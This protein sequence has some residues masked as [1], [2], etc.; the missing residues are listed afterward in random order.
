MLRLHLLL[1]AASA[2]AS[3]T[4]TGWAPVDARGVYR[5][6]AIGLF[7]DPST[8]SSTLRAVQGTVAKYPRNPLFSQDKP[9]ET[10]IDNGY[11]NVVYD[12]GYDAP[13]RLWYGNIGDGGQYLLY[14]NSSDGIAWDKPD[15]NRYDLREKW[16]HNPVV[17]KFGKHNNIVMFGGGLGMYRDLHEKDPKLRY[18]ISGGSPGGCYNSDG[19]RDCVVGTAG[20]PDG[21]GEWGDVRTLGF[22]SPW[23]PDC[24]TNIIYD[25]TLGQYLMTTR[26]YQNPQGR[27]ISI[28]RTGKRKEWM[29]EWVEACVNRRMSG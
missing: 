2:S 5:H 16:K 18:K 29:S 27:E 24:H 3:D 21:I 12:P 19:S 23:R 11:P 7:I 4:P 1:L 8:S 6:S 14:A 20:S 28:A 26:D 15:L 22:P 25:D 17:A 13:W 10:R 9:W